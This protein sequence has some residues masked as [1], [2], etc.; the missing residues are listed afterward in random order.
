MKSGEGKRVFSA[1]RQGI[2][3]L[4]PL[5]A[6]GQIAAS[7]GLADQV[8]LIDA[9]TNA[10]KTTVKVAGGTPRGLAQIGHCLA[11]GSDVAKKVTFYDLR[12]EEPSVVGEWDL[13]AT[14][15]P[16]Y[17]IFSLAADPRTGNVFVRAKDICSSCTVSRNRVLLAS[18]GGAIAKTC[19]N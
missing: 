10:V 8:L 5:P 17:N 19:A 9:A 2:T 18:D 4:L 6:R 16:L 3:T 11:V 7:E 1:S 15:K 13:S 14:A 12:K